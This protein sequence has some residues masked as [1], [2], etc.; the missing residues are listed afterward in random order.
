MAHR[1]KLPNSRQPPRNP[2]R[3]HKASHEASTFSAR[4]P[5]TS[6]QLP[7]LKQKNV[8][9]QPTRHEEKYNAITETPNR[10]AIYLSAPVVDPSLSGSDDFQCRYSSPCAS[11]AAGS[12]E[13]R[14]FRHLH[15]QRASP[16]N[17][18][19]DKRCICRGTDVHSRPLSEK[20]RR[21]ACASELVGS[22][23]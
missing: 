9:P 14:R 16:A 18:V 1:L 15:A 8:G 22:D 4:A 12:A 19:P 23:G 11:S 20:S 13:K 17:V 3:R 10:R 6:E 7:R 21:C 2:L 5:L